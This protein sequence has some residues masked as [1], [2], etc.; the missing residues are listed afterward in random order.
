MPL[1]VLFLLAGVLEISVLVL[2]SNYIGSLA[3]VG[4][5]VLG[6]VLGTWLLRLEGRRTV[7]EV[8]EAARARRAPTRGIE[9]GLI[10]AACGI[11]IVVPGLI[12]DVVGLIGLLPPVRSLVR[13]RLQR[14]AE[15]RSQQVQDEMRKHAYG[16][17][18]GWAGPGWT[19]ADGPGAGPATGTSSGGRGDFID[20]EVVSVDEDGST[21]DGHSGDG[22]SGGGAAGDGSTPPHQLPPQRSS[23]ADRPSDR[24]ER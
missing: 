15:R 24:P 2:T 16:V 3:T 18:T 6:A 22:N 14:A 5:L 23:R 21:G 19:G 20:G 10:I 8:T 4:L 1:P 7:R 11:L 12:S 9:D 17:G 13:R